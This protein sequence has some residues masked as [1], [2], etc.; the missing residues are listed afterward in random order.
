MLSISLVVSS[1]CFYRLLG[2]VGCLFLHLYGLQTLPPRHDYAC[3]IK[4]ACLWGA[5]GFCSGSSGAERWTKNIRGGYDDKELGLAF[6]EAKDAGWDQ[7]ER[8]YMDFKAQHELTAARERAQHAWLHSRA[9][10]ERLCNGGAI[11]A[12]VGRVIFRTDRI[13]WASRRRT[14]RSTRASS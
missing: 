5:S 10:L 4:L 9:S 8:G 2:I 3:T 13:T 14:G 11:G 1:T 12:A 7:D 6:E